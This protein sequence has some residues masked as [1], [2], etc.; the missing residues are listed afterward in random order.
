MIFKINDTAN[1]KLLENINKLPF[2]AI[3]L[4]KNFRI[5]KKNIHAKELLGFL[6][7]GAV[8]FDV[9]KTQD[10]LCLLDMK[11]NDICNIMLSFQGVEFIAS[12]ICGTDFHIAIFQPKISMRCF[13]N[14]GYDVLVKI[15]DLLQ[16]SD[17]E[18]EI[19]RMV[20]K[21][22]SL[23]QIPHALNFF[24]PE[25]IFKEV[26]RGFKSSYSGINK[27][28]NFFSC[29]TSLSSGSAQDF[30]VA[31][32]LMLSFCLN[33]GDE[34]IDVSIF[35]EDDGVA[36]SLKTIPNHCSAIYDVI[37]KNSQWIYQISLLAE[38]N[39]WQFDVD[40]T[41]DSLEFTLKLLDL[42]DT[43][44][45]IFRDSHIPKDIFEIALLISKLR[46]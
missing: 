1:D 5:S 43:N 38:A 23:S 41:M 22:L 7:K 18:G 4:D 20:F 13:K 39:I 31:V 16:K 24:S 34:S 37:N 12:I 17:I 46:M 2:P 9:F 29:R 6:K 19:C 25:D 42:N 33:C 40:A 45:C 30:A 35:S 14:S 32:G 11:A 27:R 21:H 28:I 26:V 36:F 3:V 44:D 8:L 10:D 15:E